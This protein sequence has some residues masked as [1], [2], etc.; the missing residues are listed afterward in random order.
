MVTTPL[1]RGAVSESDD[2]MASKDHS[3]LYNF[4]AVNPRLK[5][6]TYTLVSSA[7]R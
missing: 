5:T 1:L 3:V 6:P 7:D 4:L 2:V